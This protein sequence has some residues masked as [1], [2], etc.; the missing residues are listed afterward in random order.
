MMRATLLIPIAWVSLAGGASAQSADTIVERHINALGGKRALE[1]ITS[2]VVTRTTTHFS[3]YRKFNV[4][5]DDKITL[6]GEKP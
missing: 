5:S 3:D 6:P 2:S 4:E 1:Q